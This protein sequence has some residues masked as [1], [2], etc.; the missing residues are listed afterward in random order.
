[1]SVPR[2]VRREVRNTILD[3]LRALATLKDEAEQAEEQ[4]APGEE[5]YALPVPD[6]ERALSALSAAADYI[7]A[8][9]P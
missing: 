6:L 1:M 5:R 3:H 4:Y 2:D 7:D 8:D 9:S